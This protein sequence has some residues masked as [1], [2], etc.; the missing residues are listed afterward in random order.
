M[1][2][3]LLISACLTG[4]ECNYKGTFC[5]FS[6]ETSDV[7]HKLLDKYDIVPVCPEQLGGLSTPRIASE[8]QGGTGEDVLDS[9]ASVMSKKGLDV[10][11]N[12]L[13]GAREAYR[14]AELTGSKI[15]LLQ[16]NSPSCGCLNIHNGSYK[17]QL[18]Q[19]M[20]VAA[21]LL[22]RMGVKVV[23]ASRISEII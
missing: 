5:K 6:V 21:A 20:G 16:T 23:D 12:F 22:N 17:G 2:P 4:V 7:L 10:T 14:I 15:A 11:D 9:K 1:K 19:G 18:R 13:K 3:K 8:I